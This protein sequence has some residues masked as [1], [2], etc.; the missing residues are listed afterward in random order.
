MEN[1]ALKLVFQIEKLYVDCQMTEMIVWIVETNYKT[2]QVHFC[3][4]LFISH[5]E[6]ARSNKSCYE[7]L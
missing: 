4:L 1:S 5:E 7:F 2:E 3:W 6:K